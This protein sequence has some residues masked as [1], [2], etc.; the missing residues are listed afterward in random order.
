M[1]QKSQRTLKQLKV[2]RRYTN[3]KLLIYIGKSD[4]FYQFDPAKA[5]T[6]GKINLRAG[7]EMVN[8]DIRDGENI[9]ND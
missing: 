4:K 7:I 8:F 3:K 9:E 5:L 1:S 2:F 6:E